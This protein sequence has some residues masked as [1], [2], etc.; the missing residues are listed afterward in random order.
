LVKK[1]G[2]KGKGVGARASAIVLICLCGIAASAG[3][4]IGAP[5]Q[6]TSPTVSQVGTTFATLEASINPGGK[7]TRYHFEYGTS[8]CAPGPCTRIPLPEAEILAGSSPVH[9]EVKVEGLTLGTLYHFLLSAKNGE[10]GTIK[11]AD[12]V[13][14]TRGKPSAGLPDGRIYEQSSP[15]NKDGNDAVGGGGLIKAADDGEA[16]TFQSTFGIPGGVGA[17]VLPTY[18]GSRNGS[19]WTTQGLLPAPIFGE[20]ARVFGWLPD[21]SETVVQA[22]K[23]GTPRVRALLLQSTSDGPRGSVKIISPYTPKTEYSYVGTDAGASTFFFEAQA[24]LP[25]EEGEDPIEGAIE[26]RQNLYA[27]DRASGRLSL[28]GVMNDGKA[29]ARGTLAGPYDWSKG[30]TPQTQREGGAARGYYLQGTHAI[31]ASGDIYFTEAGTGQLYRRLNPTRPQSEV[32]AGKC[33]KVADACTVH[34]SASKR[35]VPDP[36]GAQPAAFQAASAEGSKVFFT[37]PEELTDESNTGPD[38][39]PASIGI[40]S[41]STGA[42]EDAG[43]IPKRAVG[44]AVDAAHVYWADPIAGTIGRANIDGTNVEEAFI[45]VGQSECELETEPGVSEPV[46]AESRPRYVAVDAGHVYWTNTG[47]LNKNGEPIDGGGTI[48]R[49]D[50]DGAEASIDPDFICGASNPQGIAVNATHIY[51]AN[52]AKDSNRSAIGRADIDGGEVE[53]E[54]FFV[55]SSRTP[56]G[57]ALSA[58]H[59]YFSI[60]NGS[61]FGYLFRIPLDGGAE[62]FFGLEDPGIR[63]VAINATN[64]YWAT[65]TQ[66]DEAIGTIPLADFPAFGPCSGIPSCDTD[67][68]KPAG[69]LFGLA[70]DTSHLYWSV[71]GE[72]P[73]NPGNDLYRYEPAGDTLEDMSADQGDENGAEVQGVLGVSEDGSHVYFA[74]NGDLDEGGPASSGN[75][76][77]QGAHGPLLGTS[78]SCNIYLR[79]GA[80]TKFVARVKGSDA[81]DW[82]GTPRE[83]G[84]TSSYEPKPSFLSEDGEVLLFRST[85]KLSAYDN[86]GVGEL[87]RFSAAEEKIACL[88]CPP[89]GETV[90]KGPSLESVHFP[91]PLSPPLTNVQMVQGRNLSADGTRAFFETAEALASEDTNGALDVYEWRSPGTGA[92]T[93]GGPGYSVLNEGCIYLISTGKSPFPSLFADASRSGDDVLFFT[94]QGL[95][96]Q[97]KDELQDVY[98]ARVGGG[99]PSQNPPPP[100]PCLSVGAC[101]GP[102]QTPPSEPAAGSATFVGPANPVPKHKKA[103][104]KKKV[105]H[106]KHGKQKKK[107]KRQMR[108]GAEEGQGR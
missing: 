66:G 102:S 62:E 81:L 106:R 17:Q 52:A 22:E 89:G 105:K 84:A 30:I 1:Q 48:G 61:N 59:V 86:E 78:G 53:E 70:A 29:P 108:A 79:S 3:S 37:S 101:H 83:L 16:I 58:T 77:T 76:Q 56:Y 96:G 82:T 54:F 50:I 41:S 33:T 47:V 45:E 10:G 63:G 19:E 2:A 100:N 60:T 71:N 6:I 42:I 75:C 98:D 64:L 38:Q 32:V 94:R 93:E 26:G 99:L 12:R 107:G 36:A 90:G 15:V 67:F 44:V 88:S 104:A 92:C 34:V 39:P 91:E 35:T 40:G 8:N 73:S 87:Y 14:A 68:V 72:S 97:D 43:F 55:D 69:K 4:A 5:P 65:Q 24:A 51:W 103:K 95:V 46:P 21:F 9:V 49:A 57:V 20:R 25:P 28:A 23:L 85:E 74:A 27:W 7:L 11:S 13:F 31:T 18:L 80:G